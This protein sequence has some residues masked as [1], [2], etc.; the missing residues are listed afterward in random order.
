MK[1]KS[2]LIL[3]TMALAFG[4]AGL[5]AP[6]IASAQLADDDLDALVEAREI[7]VTIDNFVLPKP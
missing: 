7:P 1:S 5:G 3:A 6:V 4:A 2:I